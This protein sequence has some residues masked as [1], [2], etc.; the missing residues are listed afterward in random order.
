MM[1]E[2]RTF[3]LFQHHGSSEIHQMFKEVNNI[4]F[5]NLDCRM[6]IKESIEWLVDAMER[7]KRT[8]KLRVRAGVNG[9]TT[10]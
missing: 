5:L 1:G 10:A 6:G 2:W 9:P 3:F 8:E 7:S 4:K